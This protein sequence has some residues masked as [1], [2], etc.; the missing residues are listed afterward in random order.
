MTRISLSYLLAF[1]IL[2]LGFGCSDQAEKTDSSASTTTDTA[3]KASEK[4]GDWE[5]CVIGFYPEN[6]NETLPTGNQQEI[7]DFEKTIGRD[8]RLR[9]LVSNLG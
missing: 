7:D 1:L 9:R 5:G 3:P 8:R 4:E 6:G 2:F